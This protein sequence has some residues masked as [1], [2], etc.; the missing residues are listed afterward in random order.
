MGKLKKP[1]AQLGDAEKV[2]KEYKPVSHTRLAIILREKGFSI[3]NERAKEMFNLL[4]TKEEQK[5]PKPLKPLVQEKD[6]PK[7]KERGARP[8]FEDVAKKTREVAP[9]ESPKHGGLDAAIMRELRSLLED[10]HCNKTEIHNLEDRLDNIEL[11][12]SILQKSIEQI[13]I[14]KNK[15]AVLE[16]TSSLY[17]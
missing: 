1:S 16:A 8:S 17:K 14:L 3:G 10:I 11:R 5:R 6:K 2:F 9:S 15:V 4:T 7:K 12:L 13:D